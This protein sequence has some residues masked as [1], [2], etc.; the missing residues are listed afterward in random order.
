MSQYDDNLKGALFKNEK[1]D[2]ES[3]PNYRGSCEINGEEFWISAWIKEISKGQRAGEMFM[4]LSF[5]AKEDNRSRG[6]S[7]PARPAPVDN[8]DDLDDKIPF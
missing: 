5:Q 7:S 4:S 3:Q 8:G 1:R 2:K 6:R